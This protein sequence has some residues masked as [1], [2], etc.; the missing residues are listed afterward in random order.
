M[1][2]IRNFS[3]VLVVIFLISSCKREK[4][5]KI[6]EPTIVFQSEHLIITQLSPRAYLHTSYLSTQEF[7]KVECNGLLVTDSQEAVVY[8]TPA[9]SI[10]SEELIKWVQS[11]LKS[12]INGVISTHFHD[13]CIAGLPV[14]HQYGIAS[15]ASQKT[16]DLVKQKNKIVPQNA[17]EDYLVLDVGEVKILA[18]YFGEGHTTDNV[19]GFFPK[20]Q[21]LFG[22]CLIKALDASKGNL[23]DANV[24]AW[25]ETVKKLKHAYPN[26]Q[27]VIPGHGKFGDAQLIEYT[28]QLFESSKN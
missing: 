25:S 28:I 16:I 4:T 14:F 23:E 13:D 2:F 1:N 15:Y 3:I 11:E 6:F 21:M 18:K 26:V 9:D 5:D 27:V 8:D 7:G 19:V 10:G 24:L 22:G 20:E 12:T 17:F